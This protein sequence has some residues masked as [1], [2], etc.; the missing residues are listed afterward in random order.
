MQNS[1]HAH[2]IV[3][4]FLGQSFHLLLPSPLDSHLAVYATRSLLS[5]SI[6]SPYFIP[7]SPPPSVSVFHVERE[8]KGV[9]F[10]PLQRSVVSTPSLSVS[11]FVCLS[12]MSVSSVCMYDWALTQPVNRWNILL[13]W[14]GVILKCWYGDY[15]SIELHQICTSGIPPPCLVG[16]Y[17]LLSR[18]L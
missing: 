5:V 12:F 2:C 15:Y 7:L 8:E 16:S 9:I 1:I 13:R 11:V 4:V 10:S 14:I 18:H 6:F 3:S 17:I